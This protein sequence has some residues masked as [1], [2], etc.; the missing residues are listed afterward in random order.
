VLSHAF[1]PY[2]T[3]KVKGTGLGLAIAR[4]MTAA[5][6]GTLTAASRLGQGTVF[7]LTFPGKPGPL[8]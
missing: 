5:Q 2:V 4:E 6:G 3:T 7:T 1:E 8:A